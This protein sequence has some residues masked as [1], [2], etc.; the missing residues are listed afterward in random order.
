MKNHEERNDEKG[1]K[2]MQTTDQGTKN[3]RNTSLVLKDEVY[4][5]IGAAI[6]VHRELG[7]GFLEAVYQEAMEIEL[8]NR[9]IPFERTKRIEIRYKGITLKKEYFADLVCYNQIIVELKALDTISGKEESQLLNYLKATGL[10]LGLLI[11]FGSTGK[12]EWRRMIL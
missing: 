11:N 1:E 10:R 8:L 3:I 7:C 6:D 12:L 9:A 4:A 5:V 2:L